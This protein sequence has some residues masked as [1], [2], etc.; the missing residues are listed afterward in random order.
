M[1]SAIDSK[2]KLAV[3]SQLLSFLDNNGSGCHLTI[4]QLK[5]L[6]ERWGH[7]RWTL[8]VTTQGSCFVSGFTGPHPLLSCP[9]FPLP[10]ALAAIPNSTPVA[11]TGFI[12]LSCGVVRP[13]TVSKGL[14]AQPSLLSK[15][16]IL[17]VESSPVRELVQ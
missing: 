16:N 12:F 5:C 4:I 8:L 9:R 1:L 7:E 17:G 13:R 15:K 10:L 2:L 14:R 11:P 6:T 3:L